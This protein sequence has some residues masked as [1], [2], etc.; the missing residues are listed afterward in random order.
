MNIL[1]GTLVLGAL[2]VWVWQ[3]LETD[4]RR[5]QAYAGVWRMIQ[6]NLPRLIVALISAG[7]FAELLPQD[8][9]RAYLGE[10]SGFAGV[11]LG[12]LLGIATPGG[13]FVSFALAA[14][15]MEAGATAPAMVAYLASWSL[16]ALT[17]VI[18]EEMAFL[19]PRFVMTRVLFTWPIPFIAGGIALLF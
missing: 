15:A 17:K 5:R 6:N 4:A 13:A 7:L 12:T 2:A 10:A 19:G 9:V 16:F 18:T 1:I 3:K 8:M 14:G 11:V